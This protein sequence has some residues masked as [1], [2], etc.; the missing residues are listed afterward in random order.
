MKKKEATDTS[1]VNGVKEETRRPPR[2]HGESM[3]DVWLVLTGQNPA[4]IM[5]QI[6]GTVI[7]DGGTRPVWQ[8]TAGNQEYVLMA[9]PQ[10]SPIRAA[11]LMSGK[12]KGNLKPVSIVP[13]LEGLPNDLEVAEIHPR[14]VDAGADVGVAMLED[15]NPMWFY[16]PL[17][18]RDKDDLTPGVIHTFWLSGV[19]LNIRKALLDY[20]TLTQ[21]YQYELYAQNWLETHPDKKSADVPPL[22]VGIKNRHIIMPGRHFG[23]YQIRAVI[24]KVEDWMFE[25]MPVKALYLSFPFD[26]RQPMSLAIYAS[27]FVLGNYTPQV[28]DEIEAYVWLEGRIIDL[29]EPAASAKA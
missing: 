13:L 4:Q 25:K 19:A 22:K 3:G 28:G 23:E 29:E 15:K 24:Q 21:G 18:Q 26:D 14:E 16:D 9:W 12:E 2:I 1:L 27:Q 7:A 20:I 10:E 6:V 5:P 17:Y 11:V 8:W